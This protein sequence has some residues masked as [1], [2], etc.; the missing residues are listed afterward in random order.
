M[1]EAAIALA[2]RGARAVLIKGGHARGKTVTD[3]LYDGRRFHEI[4]HPRVASRATHGTGCALS[5]AIA[6]NLALGLTLEVSVRR[7]I[8][9]LHAGLKRGVFP[10]RGWG[11]PARRP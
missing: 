7:A 4:V 2:A 1:R 11:F 6:A 10:G 9:Y 5:S 8:R 3:L